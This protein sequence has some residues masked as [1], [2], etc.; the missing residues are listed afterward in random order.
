[1]PVRT[2]L[3]GYLDIVPKE[4]YDHLAFFTPVNATEPIWITEGDWGEVTQIS[5]LDESTGA[6]SVSLN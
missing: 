5:G 2:P 4:G 6:V 1:V 3:E